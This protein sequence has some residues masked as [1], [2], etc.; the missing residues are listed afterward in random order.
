MLLSIV[1]KGDHYPTC[2]VQENYTLKRARVE[3]MLQGKTRHFH[4]EHG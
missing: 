3:M 2:W 4:P 1:P